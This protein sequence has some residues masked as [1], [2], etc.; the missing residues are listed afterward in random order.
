MQVCGL[1]VSE[2][3]PQFYYFHF[4]VNTLWK[5]MNRLISLAQLAGAVEYTDISAEVKIPPNEF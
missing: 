2:F 5:C 1:E 4:R 3:N